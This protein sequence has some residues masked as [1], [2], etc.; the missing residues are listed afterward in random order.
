MDLSKVVSKL[1][2]IQN[3]TE[4]LKRMEDLLEKI[5]E[6]NQRSEKHL[7]NMWRVYDQMYSASLR[8]QNN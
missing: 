2:T 7:E 6:S 1:D 4:R 8:Q 5:L 3:D